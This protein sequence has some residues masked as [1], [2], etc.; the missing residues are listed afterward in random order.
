MINAVTNNNSQTPTGSSSMPPVDP[1]VPAPVTPTPAEVKKE[2]A[3]VAPPFNTAAVVPPKVLPSHA[4]PHTHAHHPA[5]PSLRPATAPHTDISSLSESLAQKINPTDE[6]S[7]GNSLGGSVPPTPPNADNNSNND[8][9]AP[10]SETPKKKG[11]PLKTVLA[12]LVL[13]LVVIGGGA[14]YWLSQTS[15]DIRQQAATGVYPTTPPPATTPPPSG[16]NCQQGLFNCGGRS[17]SDCSSHAGQGCYYS[18]SSSSCR[19]GNG[20]GGQPPQGGGTC[21]SGGGKVTVCAG[22]TALNV[23]VTECSQ[24]GDPGDSCNYGCGG[25]CSDKTIAAN[26]CQSFGNSLSCGKWQTDVHGD[27]S[28]SSSDCSRDCGGGGGTPPP[29]TPPPTQLSATASLSQPSCVAIAGKYQAGTPIALSGAGTNTTRT[30]IYL[31]KVNAAGNNLEVLTTCPIGQLVPNNPKFCKITESATNP[32]SSWTPTEAQIGKYVLT[33]NGYGTGTQCSGNPT[34]DFNAGSGIATNACTGWSNCSGDDY[35]VFEVV[36]A[37]SCVTQKPAKPTLVAKGCIKADGT[38]Q[39]AEFLELSWT[40]SPT[41]VQ[42]VNIN[43]TGNFNSGPF[44]NKDVRTLANN[45]T[46]A[47]TGFNPQAGAGAF[48]VRVGKYY[49]YAWDGTQ[50]SDVAEVTVETCPVVTPPP[51]APICLNIK[52]YDS[53]NNLVT[54]YSTLKPGDKVKF[55]CGQ[56]A[57]VVWYSFRVLELDSTGKPYNPNQ[58]PLPSYPG[59]MSTE[60]TI[61]RAGGFKA[62]C[63]ICPP[64]SSNPF[65][66]ECQAFED[67]GS[68]STQPTPTPAPVETQTACPTTSGYQCLSSLTA[69]TDQGGTFETFI[70]QGGTLTMKHTCSVSTQ[71]CCKMP[72]AGGP[73]PCAQ[74]ASGARCTLQSLCSNGTVIQGTCSSSALV[75]CKPN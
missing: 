13:A 8:Q 46:T 29:S 49:A 48:P 69:C 24:S 12:A 17:P 27:V 16:S 38:A 20:G 70:P 74:V 65:D 23:C 41:V 32:S 22:S 52:M 50:A 73:P 40:D 36:S 30:E 45:V 61:P 55:G 62:Q 37:V 68:G 56:V 14:T 44:W 2:E 34:C 6:K 75:C 4:A 7:V 10:T 11:F 47:P 35:K 18:Q 43:T 31:S 58:A 51:T 26:T 57:G 67:V 39:P 3:V 59:S 33:V 25:G 64:K 60:Y 21:S 9:A 72:P 19:C 28:C 54:N 53:G 15:Q 66:V 63:A 71:V 42:V 1:V 5:A